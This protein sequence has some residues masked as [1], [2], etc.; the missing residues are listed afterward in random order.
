MRY[1]CR[2]CSAVEASAFVVEVG[3]GVVTVGGRVRG[4]AAD[5]DHAVFSLRLAVPVLRVAILTY[6]PR[7]CRRRSSGAHGHVE[8]P[9]PSARFSSRGVGEC[10]VQAQPV[11]GS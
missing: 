7:T 1:R 10:E 9:V 5:A 8:E 2:R 6:G 4:D 3:E 11:S